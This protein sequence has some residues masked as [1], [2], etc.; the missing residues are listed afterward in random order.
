MHGPIQENFW[1]AHHDPTGKYVIPNN[2]KKI[3][4][5]KIRD[6]DGNIKEIYDSDRK[7]PIRLVRDDYSE[8]QDMENMLKLIEKTE[9]TEERNTVFIENLYEIDGIRKYQKVDTIY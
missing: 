5:K 2:R 3:L 4:I 9:S 8:G 1:K 6:P 7:V